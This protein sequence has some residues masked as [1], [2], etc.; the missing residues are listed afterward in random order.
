MTTAP[1]LGNFI[2]GHRM[3]PGGATSALVDPSI[4]ELAGR[5]TISDASDVDV[6]LRAAEAAFVSWRRSTPRER[7]TALL[8]LAD[9][10]EQRA[11]EFADA[12]CRETGKPREIVLTEEIP[13][14]AD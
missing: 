1:A 4:G 8:R 5:A 13:Q 12:E 3:A 9:A 10:L 6:A 2:A 7:Q 14:C 11:E